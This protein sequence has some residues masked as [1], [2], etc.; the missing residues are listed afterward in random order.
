MSQCGECGRWRCTHSELG[1]VGRPSGSLS[2]LVR[3]SLDLC[4]LPPPPPALL[5]LL[6]VQLL[7]LLL[8]PPPPAPLLLLLL[9][10]SSG[11]SSEAA[12]SAAVVTAL[13]LF[14]PAGCRRTQV[15][16]RQQLLHLLFLYVGA[17]AAAWPTSLGMCGCVEER[18]GPLAAGRRSAV[19]ALPPRLLRVGS[20]ISRRSSSIGDCEAGSVLEDLHEDGGV[21]G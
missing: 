1:R 3:V 11:C 16:K 21:R 6:L 5:L 15:L 13:V 7:L 4:P 14:S 8:L 20:R 19:A 12:A 2:L 17:G 9:L 10:Q 18:E